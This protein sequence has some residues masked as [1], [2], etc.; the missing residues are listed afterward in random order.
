[1]KVN[2]ISD[3][4]GSIPNKKTNKIV[5]ENGFEPE[6]LTEADVLVI[7]GDIAGDQKWTD[8]IFDFIKQKT[9]D[10]FKDY[11]LIRGNHDFYTNLDKTWSYS[12]LTPDMDEFIKCKFKK[13]GNVG[14]VCSTMWTPILDNI[15]GCRYMMNDFWC[16]KDWTPEKQTD[17]FYKSVEDMWVTMN[18]EKNNVDSFVIVTHHLP[19]YELTDVRFKKEYTMGN[20]ENKNKY[21]INEAF[22][23]CHTHPKYGNIL[24]SFKNEFRVKLWAYGH[25]HV[26]SKTYFDDTDTWF[27]C[28]PKGYASEKETSGFKYNNVL[29]I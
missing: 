18:R 1:M 3:I 10:K 8:E 7:A 12:L 16:I 4:H 9:K 20:H 2:V 6:K 19:D 5:F 28:N 14:F 13:I 15:I 17:V 23:V 24:R 27:V 26:A 25:T 22:S 29:T 21:D 11:I